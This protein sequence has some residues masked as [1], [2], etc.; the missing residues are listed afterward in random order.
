LRSYAL[1]QKQ[2]RTV[3][4]DRKPMVV[5]TLN[6]SRGR[7]PFFQIRVPAQSREEAA[8]LCQQLDVSCIVFKN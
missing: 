4:G 2:N 3:I 5:R 6:R 8:K 7:A 1:L